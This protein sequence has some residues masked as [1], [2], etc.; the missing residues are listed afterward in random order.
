M[1]LTMTII[2]PGSAMPLTQLIDL[3]GEPRLEDLQ[4]VARPWLGDALFE[5]VRVK[6]DGQITDML[7]DEEGIPKGLAFNEQAS[8]F[9]PGR[10]YGTALIFSRPIWF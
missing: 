9:Y 3:P 2:R 7:V 6:V 8:A 5:R 10:I 4:R 1:Q